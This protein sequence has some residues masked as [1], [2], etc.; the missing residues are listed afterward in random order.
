VQNYLLEGPAS[1]EELVDAFIHTSFFVLDKHMSF[2]AYL[3]ALTDG[4]AKGYNQE[5]LYLHIEKIQ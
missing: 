1:P 5:R 2:G 3:S 4:I